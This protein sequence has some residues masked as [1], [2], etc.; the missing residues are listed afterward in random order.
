MMGDAFEPPP[1]G[2]WVIQVLA[3]IAIAV[4]CFALFVYA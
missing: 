3:A 2:D 4:L 1:L